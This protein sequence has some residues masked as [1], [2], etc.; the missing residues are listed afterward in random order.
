[1]KYLISFILLIIGAIFKVE[2][3]FYV[4]IVIVLISNYLKVVET[5][6]R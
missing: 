6:W 1:M 5:K 2:I 3:L 4:V